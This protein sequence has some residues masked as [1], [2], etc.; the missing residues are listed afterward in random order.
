MLATTWPTGNLKNIVYVEGETDEL[1]LN[2]AIKI[3]KRNHLDI[4]IVW[5]GNFDSR[6]NV[7]FSGDTALNQ[8]FNYYKANP[9]A[10]SQNKKI[11]LLYDS[12]TDKPHLDFKNLYV[13]KMKK[14]SRI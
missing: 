12:D 11:I 1:Y 8:T 3:L 4:S 5:I 10:L 7:S 6:G 2:K 9:Q 13:R 14:M